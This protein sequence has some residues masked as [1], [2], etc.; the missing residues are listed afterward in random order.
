[1][2]APGSSS[3][4]VAVRVRPL[5]ARERLEQNRIC[6]T[7][8]AEDHEIALGDDRLFT[9]DQVFDLSCNQFSIYN[10]CVHD[11]VQGLFDGYNA[12]VLAYGQTGS[13]KTYT[14]GTAL[15]AVSNELTPETGVIPRAIKQL[16]E[17]MLLRVEASKDKGIPEPKFNVLVQ[18]VELYNEEIIDLLAEEKNPQGI[19]IHE[20]P[21]GSIALKGVSQIAVTGPLETMKTLTQGALNRTTGSTNMNEVSSRSHAIFTVFLKQERTSELTG[22]DDAREVEFLSAKFHFVDLAGSERLKRTGATGDRAKEGIAI[23][24]GLLSLGNVISVLG[25][26]RNGHV[27]YRDSKLTRLLQDSLGGNSQ[28]L[29]VA[30]ISPS[31]G[32]FAETL[33]TLRYANRAK[34]ITN[35]ISANQDKSSKIINELRQRIMELE[36][37]IADYEQGKKQFDCDGVEVNSLQYQE[38]MLLT[39]ERNQLAMRVKTLEAANDALRSRLVSQQMSSRRCP[40]MVKPTEERITAMSIRRLSR[41]SWNSLSGLGPNCLSP[42]PARTSSRLK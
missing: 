40:L 32:D 24:C 38:N 35:K 26:G 36:A 1:M 28:T 12:T 10:N 2:S 13:G 5:N 4:K 27:P 17:E 34:N 25:S 29:M 20:D 39:S 30:C 33:N 41:R 6:A 21:S 22:E 42:R 19:R 31:D 11:L 37:K 3:V 14:M 7:V 18:F 23:N 8:H 15:D 16:F 9:F